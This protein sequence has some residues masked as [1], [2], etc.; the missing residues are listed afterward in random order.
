MF[1]NVFLAETYAITMPQLII[2]D[3][4]TFL[5]D[6]RVDFIRLWDPWLNPESPF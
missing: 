2:V 5:L 3:F 6:L 4:E 1:F